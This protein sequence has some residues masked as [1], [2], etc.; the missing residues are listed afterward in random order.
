MKIA[1]TTDDVKTISAH[2]ESTQFYLVFTVGN[3]KIIRQELRLK[4]NDGHFLDQEQ[5][6][7]H[8][9]LYGTNPQSAAKHTDMIGTIIDCDVLLTRGMN[10]VVYDDLKIRS[11]LP[12]ITNIPE[13]QAAVEAYLGGN[14]I[15]HL[16]KLY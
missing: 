10:R 16:E 8:N 13:A 1:V 11:I 14:L 2:F 7:T 9:G 4:A 6:I 15:N 5:G 3:G 12:I